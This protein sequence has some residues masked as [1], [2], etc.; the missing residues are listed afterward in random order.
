[1]IAMGGPTILIVCVSW[2]S[3]G[4]ARGAQIPMRPKE[5]LPT[6]TLVTLVTLVTVTDRGGEGT[7]PSKTKALCIAAFPVK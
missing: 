3:K 6:G 7:P 1:M 4:L 2:Q 5:M